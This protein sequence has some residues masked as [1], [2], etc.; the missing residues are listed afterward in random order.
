ML[1]SYA[2]YYDNGNNSNWQ[3]AQ[4]PELSFAE[5]AAGRNMEREPQYTSGGASDRWPPRYILRFMLWDL[6]CELMLRVV[7][8]DQS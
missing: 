3:M 5:K 2:Y 4:P 8:I 6:N 1:G 7:G